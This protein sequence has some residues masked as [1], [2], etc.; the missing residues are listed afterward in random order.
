M[1]LK[2]LLDFTRLL[3]EGIAK[4]MNL[5]KARRLETANHLNNLAQ[6]FADFEPAL[7]VGNTGKLNQLLART[8]E[9][10]NLLAENEVVH[11]VVGDARFSAMLH[12][13]REVQNAKETLAKIQSQ[14]QSQDKMQ[15]SATINRAIGHLEA[16]VITLRAEA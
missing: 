15:A 2:L 13:C 12:T 14:D 1:D 5:D 4:L 3:G 9:L 10:I 7:H 8:R 6:T 11:Q 16:H